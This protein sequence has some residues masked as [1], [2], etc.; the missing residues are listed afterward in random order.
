[1]ETNDD[2]YVTQRKNN[3]VDVVGNSFPYQIVTLKKILLEREIQPA[4]SQHRVNAVK[5]LRVAT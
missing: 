3:L 2:I 5:I 4:L 1:M